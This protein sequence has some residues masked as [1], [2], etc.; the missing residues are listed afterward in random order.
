[1]K[2]DYKYE[3]IITICEENSDRQITA[4]TT[5]KTRLFGIVQSFNYPISY[6]KNNACDLVLK[7]I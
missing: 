3:N 7:G 6:S 5:T 2:V 1:M 4:T